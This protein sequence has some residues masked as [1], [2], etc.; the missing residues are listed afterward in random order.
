MP[1][2]SVPAMMTAEHLFD[3]KVAAMQRDSSTYC[4]EPA[5]AAAYTAFAATFDAASDET[6]NAVEALLAANSFMKVMSGRIVPAVVAY[7]VFWSRYFFNL[8]LLE[9]ERDAAETE[10]VSEREAV[11]REA[12]TVG[13]ESGESVDASTASRASP[14]T[15]EGASSSKHLGDTREDENLSRSPRRN[16]TINPHETSR[17]TSRERVIVSGGDGD[18]ASASAPG[19]R[20]VVSLATD[21][22]TVASDDSLGRD[23]TRVRDV[24]SPTGLGEAGADADAESDARHADA[25]ASGEEKMDEPEPEP[26]EAPE[27]RS[28]APAEPSAAAA[29]PTPRAPTGAGDDSD[30]DEDWGM[31]SD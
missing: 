1:A 17:E 23:W 5:D 24:E 3:K 31:D 27:R 16:D 9:R 22:G 19:H 21:D 11:R 28:S 14:G 12:A 25:E 26:E 13:S 30:L 7:D 29:R 6:K 8:R 18:S 2:S 15:P 4:D 20:R 10:A